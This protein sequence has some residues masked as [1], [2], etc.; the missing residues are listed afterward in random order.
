MKYDLWKFLNI[1][2]MWFS[3]EDEDERLPLVFLWPA[4]RDNVKIKR[5][6]IL[7]KYKSIYNSRTQILKNKFPNFLLYYI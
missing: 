6:I 1:E 2:F 5:I 7:K 3:R 4:S